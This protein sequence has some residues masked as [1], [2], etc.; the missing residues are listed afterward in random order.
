MA[1]KKT[2]P[3][4]FDT[5]QIKDEVVEIV[6]PE[7]KKEELKKKINDEYGLDGNRALKIEICEQIEKIN[8]KYYLHVIKKYID[9]LGG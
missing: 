2:E 4:Y 5:D 6:I 3:K 8:N 9:N 7:E 1:R